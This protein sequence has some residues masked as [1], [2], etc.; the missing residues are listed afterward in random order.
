MMNIIEDDQSLDEV[1]ATISDNDLMTVVKDMVARDKENEKK[2]GK[3]AASAKAVDAGVSGKGSCTKEDKVLAQLS[4]LTAQVAQQQQ[5][6]QKQY[7]QQQKAI[8]KLQHQ[9]DSR[10]TDNNEK[11]PGDAKKKFSKFIK[12]AQCERDR[13]Y[14]THC[15][16]CGS[17]DHQR[18]QCKKNE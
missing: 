15:S 4:Q 13:V 12:C 10:T 16:T 7:D 11:K 2:L 14:C 6:F 9:L 17:G 5:N 8:E 1:N 18:L 3:N